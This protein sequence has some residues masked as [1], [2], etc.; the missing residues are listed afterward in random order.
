MDYE[1]VTMVLLDNKWQ[2]VFQQELV[3]TQFQYN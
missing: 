1:Q 2:A 3:L